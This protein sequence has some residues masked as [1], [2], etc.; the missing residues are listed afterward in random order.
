MKIDPA[1]LS[2][3]TTGIVG[4][5]TL[6]FGLNSEAQ[7]VLAQ[8]IGAVI[9]VVACITYVVHLTSVAK[10]KI[11]AETQVQIQKLTT[12]VSEKSTKG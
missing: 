8:G 1:L 10:A 11:M 4:I 5:C 12:P 7:Q 6:A 3:L 2:T 9:T